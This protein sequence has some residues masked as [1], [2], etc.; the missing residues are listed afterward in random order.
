MEC[1]RCQHENRPTAKFCEE[2]ATPLKVASPDRPPAPSYVE[3]TSALTE[4]LEQ[5]TAT[6]DILK[7]ISQSQTDVQPVFEA[8]AQSA[9]RLCDAKHGL[10]FLFDGE[11]IHL[12]AITGTEQEGIEAARR[13]FPQAPGRASATTRAIQA[14]RAVV[15][16]D[17]LEDPEFALTEIVR[18]TDFRSVMSA[19]MLRGGKPIGAV[20]VTRAAA[21]PFP[22]TQVALLQ[23]FADQAVIAIENVRLFTELQEKNRALTTAHAQVS[24]SLE[25]QTAT[26]EILRV[27]S[28]SPTDLQPVMNA[29]AESAAR[30]CEATD[31]HVYQKE[32]D[33]LRVVA[34]HGAL[35][36]ARQEVPISRQT[37]IG[38]AVSDRQPIHVDDLAVAFHD[39]FPGARRMKEMG[40][41]TIL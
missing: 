25:Q 39:E 31:A 38:R 2:C 5:Q 28:S 15:I 21:A 29:V 6:G 17:V 41:R 37:V 32:G 19:P 26:S 11:L 8:I 3:V 14:L 12:A 1:L 35:P 20:T 33:L 24:E 10:V 34:S 18:V 40:Y 16:P 22:D 9:L 7:V 4:A 27:I 23:T 13:S 30:L 36:L